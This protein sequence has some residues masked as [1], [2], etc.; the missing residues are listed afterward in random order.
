MTN[1]Q[2]ILEQFEF[3]CEDG[4]VALRALLATKPIQDDR[5]EAGR[6]DRAA[7]NQA[8]RA[9][10]AAREALSDAYDTLGETAKVRRRS[11]A[12]S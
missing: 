6:F 5:T 11:G 9:L 3:G 12:S 7:L 4:L 2:R 10:D 8:I 1:E